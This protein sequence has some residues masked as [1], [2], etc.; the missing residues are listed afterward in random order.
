MTKIFD[1]E[2]NHEIP[3][4]SIIHCL[5]SLFKITD[6]GL[7]H[8]VG[9]IDDNTYFMDLQFF[10]KLN[11]L[12]FSEQAEVTST[13]EAIPQK[14]SLLASVYR[15]MTAPFTIRTPKNVTT[16]TR[17]RKSSPVKLVNPTEITGTNEETESSS[18]MVPP[19]NEMFLLN[20][21][22]E[23]SITDEVQLYFKDYQDFITSDNQ[24]LIAV[25][26]AL[27]AANM[28]CYNN[29]RIRYPGF[30]LEPPVTDINKL[31]SV[32]QGIFPAQVLKYTLGDRIKNRASSSP[33]TKNENMEE[34]GLF[35]P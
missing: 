5:G 7:S 9:K 27:N 21:R 24:K 20:A 15:L 19:P 29:L 35:L 17:K 8:V 4:G 28:G 23:K 16:R 25:L 18:M 33:D 10:R 30:L 3:K 13:P 11:E 14:E 2:E 22:C 1:N 6:S 32:V 31:T 34:V 26:S 12:A